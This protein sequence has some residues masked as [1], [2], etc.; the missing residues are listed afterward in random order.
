MKNFVLI[1]AGLLSGTFVLFSSSEK[2]EA[3]AISKRPLV[4]I[5]ECA[6]SGSALL[7]DAVSFKSRYGMEPLRVRKNINSLTQAEINA[8]K[9]GVLKMRALPYTNPTSWT[10][11]SAIHGTTL[12]DNLPLWNSCH[13]PTEA[14]FFLAWHRMFVYFFERILRAKSGRANLTIPY[15]DY[16]TNLVM[17][18][19]FR[20]NT[21]GNPLYVANRN[22]AINS[23]GALPLSIQTAFNN[24]LDLIPY[25]TFQSNLNTGPHGSVHTTINGDMAAVTTAAK[26]P[27]FWVHHSEIDRLWEVWRSKCGGRANPTD[28]TWLNKTFVFYD[29]TG[30]PVA[31]KGSQVVEISTQ[32]NYK[33]DDLPAVI[34]CPAAR[35]ATV[36]RQPLITKEAT[37][38]LH[39]QKQKAE[40]ARESAASLDEF[41]ATKHRSTFNFSSTTA[42][43]R[44][45]ITFEGLRIQEMPQ[46]VIEVYLN[47]PAGQAP[48][49]TSKYFVGLLD[50]F[51]AEHHNNHHSA[52]QNED[53]VEM[54]ATKAARALGLTV[55]SLRNASVSFYVRGVSLHGVEVTA[56]AQITIRHVKFSVDRYQ[57]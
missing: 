24:S 54:D 47:L 16:Q 55:N 8:I 34:T 38:E 31:M 36:T 14:N 4:N 12:T 17:H 33:Y 7:L 30:T 48:N 32:L 13:K 1:I 45:T 53:E 23:G 46:G 18:P 6:P 51:S 40:F 3:K 19:A 39:G 41:V 37:V 28:T 25:N 43:E 9:V 42:P 44:L 49:S 26:D 11:Q 21:P 22:A 20:D 29:E 50:L 2:K 35:P 15:W 5:V 27:I 52:A 10:Y 56:Q 57:N